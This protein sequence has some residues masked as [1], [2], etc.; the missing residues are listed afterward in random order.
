M[1]ERL[2]RAPYALA[3]DHR[4]QP[5]ADVT[6]EDLDS[7]VCLY[8]SDIDEVL[9]LNQSAAD[10]WRLA[11]GTAT[12][13]EIITRL[14]AAYQVAVDVVAADAHAVIDDLTTRGYLE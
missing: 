1:V 8:R 2:P 13:A 5:T 9:V 6:A 12:V 3:V 10:V 14:A 7:D 4:P 11:D